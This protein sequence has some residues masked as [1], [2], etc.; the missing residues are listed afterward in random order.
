MVWRADPPQPARSARHVLNK[1]VELSDGEVNMWLHFGP[2]PH[3]L[4]AELRRN[5][6]LRR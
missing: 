5:R 3:G 2:A 1:A 4:S 6:D